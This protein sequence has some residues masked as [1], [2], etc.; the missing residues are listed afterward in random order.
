[1]KSFSTDFAR[2]PLNILETFVRKYISGLQGEVSGGLIL[3]SDGNSPEL[4]GKVQ[5][6]RTSLTVV[7]LKTRYYL[8]DDVIKLE[9]N[10]LLFS[11]FTV[12]DSLKKQLTLNG[13]INLIDRRNIT[14]DLIVASDHIQV[15]NTAKKD[16]PVFNGTI[17]IDSKLNITGPVQKPSIAGNIL[18]AKGTVINYQYSENLSV[19]EAE[20]TITFTSFKEDQPIGKTSP[21]GVNTVSNLPDVKALI[22]ID[23]NSL[24]NFE[25]SSGY[26]IVIN[27]TGGGFLNYAL[28][29]NK[30]INLNGIYEI[31]QGN[32]VLKIPGWPRKDFII[33]PGSSLK[34][35]GAIDNPELHVE[36]TS[37]V[38]GSYYNRVEDK[39]READFKVYMKL[40]DRLSQLD[41]IFDVRSEDQY[42]MSILNTLSTEER[43]RQAIN[44]LIFNQVDLPDV[45][46]ASSYIYDQINSFW[47]SQLNQ[48]TKSAFK[49]VDVS[50]GIDTYTDVSKGGGEQ[51]Y[52]SFTYEVKKEMFKNRGSVLVSGRMNDNSPAGSQNDNVI[53]NFIFEYSL[54]SSRTKYFKVYRQQNWE[55]LLEGEVT[56]SGVGFIYRKN[57][58]R[59]S[60]IWR[61]KKKQIKIAGN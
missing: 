59:L 12:M 42:I 54:D 1:M 58:D 3:T 51:Q 38:R 14:A 7:P 49:N 29:P 41:V 4:N 20:K 36:T 45:T 57:Y 21:P 35:D 50:V 60:D 31:N 2:I 46:S 30:T 44:L 15:M 6:N 40:A 61:Q 18:L 10:K 37:K 11:Q 28:M 48:L 26:D 47:E 25:I 56:K 52:T 34:W 53:E 13:A 17:F 33:T 19:S 23:P 22:E 24:F 55:D 16:N 43:M 5:I 9:N 8:S 39:N 32:A 27:I